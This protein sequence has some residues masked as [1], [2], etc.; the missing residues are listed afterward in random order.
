MDVS[1]THRLGSSREEA[2]DNQK[3]LTA[4]H[5]ECYFEKFL[6]DAGQNLENRTSASSEALKSFLESTKQDDRASFR[7]LLERSSLITDPESLYAD[8]K[9]RY[10]PIEVNQ[11]LFLI[12]EE[13]LANKER[14]YT[15]P[16]TPKAS[17]N[18]KII[19]STIL[20]MDS[21]FPSNT[22][23][24]WKLSFMSFQSVS[25]RDLR[26]LGKSRQHGSSTGHEMS[27]QDKDIVNKLWRWLETHDQ[28]PIQLA[29]AMASHG[30]VRDVLKE[31]GQL[32]LIIDDLNG[33]VGI[34]LPLG[35]KA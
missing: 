25:I 26:W 17:E 9:R 2:Q 20:W 28:E 32:C 8:F 27:D 3:F 4:S 29:F 14:I 16:D 11:M 19:M 7:R 22:G 1:T 31:N 23:I 24:G 30:M 10:K 33:L 34:P 21:L 13:F 12:D 15:S 35:I 6:L 5:V 18:L